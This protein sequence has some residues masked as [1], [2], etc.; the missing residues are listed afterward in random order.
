ME[1]QKYILSLR[2]GNDYAI[3]EKEKI[4][5]EN[6]LIQIPPPKFIKIRENLVNTFDVVEIY[7]RQ[8]EKELPDFLP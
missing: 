8:K 6:L 7:K 2:K 1:E 4:E 5:I 3:S